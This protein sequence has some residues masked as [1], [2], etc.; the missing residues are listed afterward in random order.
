[1]QTTTIDLLRHGECEGGHVYRGRLDFPLNEK[2]WQQLRGKTQQL[3]MWT[4]IVSSPLQR[5][6]LFA[7]EVAQ[8]CNKPL[9][10]MDGFR[11]VDFGD[12]EGRLFD[13][14][15]REQGSNV[16]RFFSDPVNAAPPNGEPMRVFERRVLAAWNQLLQTLRGE[17]VLLVAH[18]GTIRILLAHVLAMPL[19]RI[20]NLEV[21]YASASRIRIHHSDEHD[22]FSTLIFHNSQF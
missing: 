21:P 12:W 8:R 13:E 2:G 20:A 10:V 6:A 9:S 14:V 11:E 16:R 4:H 17:H 19:N 22:D 15:W 18:G 3:D 5:C 7:D 1:M